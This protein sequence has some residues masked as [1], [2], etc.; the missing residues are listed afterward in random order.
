M[1]A[2]EKSLLHEAGIR[3]AAY[4][5]RRF[6]RPHQRELRAEA[7]R[8]L[9]HA[10]RRAFN[11]CGEDFEPVLAAIVEGLSPRPRDF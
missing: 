6:P 11:D 1:A 2:T 10:C 9:G 3:H 4:D 7:I 8:Q 5:V